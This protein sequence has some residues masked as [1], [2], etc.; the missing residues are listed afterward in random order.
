MN[1]V[2]NGGGVLRLIPLKMP[3][4]VP[5]EVVG[6]NV[7]FGFRLLDSILTEDSQPRVHCLRD[8][9]GSAELGHGNERDF[10]RRP[11]DGRRGFRDLV[12]DFLNISGNVLKSSSVTLF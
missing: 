7:V 3:D 8:F 11:P 5:G 2:E 12:A 4:H 1:A 10:L 9:F 6:K